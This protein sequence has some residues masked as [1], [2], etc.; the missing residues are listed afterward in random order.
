VTPDPDF[1][2]AF[3]ETR[4]F[5]LGRPARPQITP[6]G[7]AVLFLRSPSRSPAHELFELD[8]GSGQIRLLASAQTLAAGDDRP[9]TPE[10]AARR[11]RQRITDSG[12]TGFQLSP[13]GRS[14]LIPLCGRLHLLDRQGGAVRQLT[15]PEQGAPIDPR[16]S[17]DGA[18]VAFVRDGE[19]QVLD[20]SAPGAGPPAARCLTTGASVDVTHGLAEF[21]AQEEMSRHEGYWWSPA[22]D[23]LLFAEVDEREVER[24]T[25]ADPAH[26]ERAPLAF[27]YPRP[28]RA[29]ARVQL[30]VVDV[31]GSSPGAA[32]PAVT[33]LSWDRQRYPYL[34]R[35]LWDTARAPLAILVQTRDQRELALL[36]V[37]PAAGQTR[38]L[39][40]ETDPAWV[41]LDKDLPRWLPDG[42]GLLWASEA[43]GSR[44]LQLRHADGRLVRP[45]LGP[46]EQFLSLV[47]VAPDGA[48]LVFLAGD[49][50]HNRIERLDLASGR[51]TRLSNGAPADHAPVFS[52]DGR[53]WVD[54]VV[55]A[56]AMPALRVEGGAGPP[57]AVPS[58]AEDP[59]FPV[60]LQL[61]DSG[62][63]PDLRAAIVRP[64]DFQPGRKYPV[65]LHVYGGPHHL[66]VK[67]DARSYVF[68][69]YL[70]DQGCVVVALDNRGTP[71]RGRD[72]ERAIKGQLGDVPLGDQAA[73]LQA[74][75][76]RHPELDLERVGIYGWSFGGYLS[77]LAVLR[78][79]EL[80]KVAVA[81]APVVDWRDYDTHYTERY[82]DL[83]DAA[84]EAYQR[85]SLLAH[86]GGLCRPLLII[87][88]TADDNVYFFHSLKLAEALFRAG[89]AF[90][91]LPLPRVTHQIADPAIRAALWGRVAGYLIDHLV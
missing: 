4:A 23:R 38:P 64:G 77:A 41:N 47:H 53:L 72:W 11:E 76:R 90:D 31:A 8:V 84:P 71:R 58:A 55:S 40:V 54:A 36:A 32:P 85:A 78:R 19:L 25:I 63:D 7:S 52:R 79:P 59:P 51:C 75:G 69:Q 82:L 22:G 21:V 26:P 88:G 43:T 73:G 29:N 86:A 6:D 33:W 91:F 9:P 68:D 37:D 56:D 46:D 83:P 49:A 1:L 35:V 16:F 62:G 87:H 67:A 30:G 18:R 74:L 61:T 3:A 34:A 57:I 15:A 44:V 12:I 39:V 45:L 5:S 14:V 48:S 17:P 24:F 66:S 60:R 65:V 28:G 89:R 81:G 20:L 13:D 27:R 80:F 2:R 50:V 10:E 70:A 42:S